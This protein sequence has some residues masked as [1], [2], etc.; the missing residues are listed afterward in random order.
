MQVSGYNELR[1]LV[2][3]EDKGHRNC[4]VCGTLILLAAFVSMAVPLQM[5]LNMANN[6]TT[7]VNEAYTESLIGITWTWQIPE[8]SYAY[9]VYFDAGNNYSDMTQAL[10]YKE[11]LKADCESENLA[12]C[13][14][15]GSRWSI[16]YAVNLAT[17]YCYCITFFVML[18]GACNFHLR[19]CSGCC[20]TLSS[21]LAFA[22]FITSMVFR[23]NTMG[24]LAA[25][26]LNYSHVDSYELT[27]A[28]PPVQ[29]TWKND[30]TYED[31]AYAITWMIS[32]QFA[33]C[34]C[35][36]CC[37]GALLKPK[38]KEEVIVLEGDREHILIAEGRPQT[39]LMQ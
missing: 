6:F 29:F 35:T 17:A 24:K 28:R 4:Y 31:D 18:L 36:N 34:C 7:V 2:E 33:L 1:I 22:A 39:N 19:A 23:Y 12:D 5:Y 13:Y 8:A 15:K 26:S 37:T 20:V 21:C 16:I 25:L 27:L 10:Q 32:V 38:V 3:K 30:K 14:E 11:E 9:D